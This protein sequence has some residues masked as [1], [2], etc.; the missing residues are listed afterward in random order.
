[1]RLLAGGEVDSAVQVSSQERL[2]NLCGQP[3]VAGK[4]KPN[5]LMHRQCALDKKAYHARE[6]KKVMLSLSATIAAIDSLVET[7]ALAPSGG[8]SNVVL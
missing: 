3:I 1:V 5:K 4:N 7:Q 6:A 2:C 8:G